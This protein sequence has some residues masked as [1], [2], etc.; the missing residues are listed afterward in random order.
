MDGSKHTKSTKSEI[1]DNKLLNSKD[2]IHKTDFPE[3][4]I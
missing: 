4:Q 3:M 2:E 1:Y